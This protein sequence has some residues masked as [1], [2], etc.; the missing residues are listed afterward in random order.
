M[1]VAEE[2]DIEGFRP[3]LMADIPA[4]NINMIGSLIL[5]TAAA[6]ILMQMPAAAADQALASFATDEAVNAWE[7]VNDGVMGGISKGGVSRTEEGTLLFSGELSLA[8]NGGFS[9]IRTKPNSL[10]LTKDSVIVVKT[11]GDGRT[12]SIE[13]RVAGQM[14]ASSY[15]ASLPTTAGQWQ[16][17]RVSLGEFKPQAF[18]RALPFEAVNP[19]KV[20]S[21]GF[22]LADK[23]A[24]PFRLEI[25]SVTATDGEPAAAKT[26]AFG[27]GNTLVDVATA[28]GSFKTLLAGKV[29]LAEALTVGEGTTLQGSKI[30]AKFEDGRVR[31][32]SASLLK[33]DIVASNGIIHVIDG[34][35]LP[36]KSIAEPLST[37]SLSNERSDLKKWARAAQPQ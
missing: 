7:A 16:E 35:L 22:T 31:V 18:G 6:L 27:K 15:R 5:T 19:A 1:A 30:S 13:L 37:G 26:I 25:A 4:A 21:I 8:N 23:N 2:V 28:A 11:R 34:V 12:Y 33:A 32:G 10:G 20:D 17:T 36:A 9:S 3:A 14:R 29:T 24:G